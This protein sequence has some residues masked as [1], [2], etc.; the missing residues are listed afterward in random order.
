MFAPTPPLDE[1]AERAHQIIVQAISVRLFEGG[2]LGAEPTP[3]SWLGPWRT[4][5]RRDEEDLS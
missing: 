2:S 4:G 1:I 3:A 5:G